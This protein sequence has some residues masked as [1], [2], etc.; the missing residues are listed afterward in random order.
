[1]TRTRWKIDGGELDEREKDYT[2]RFTCRN[3]D[4]GTTVDITIRQDKGSPASDL[5]GACTVLGKLF[6]SV[7]E[8]ETPTDGKRMLN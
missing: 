4:K 2:A 5:V 7:S 6:L 8:G 3:L 1:M